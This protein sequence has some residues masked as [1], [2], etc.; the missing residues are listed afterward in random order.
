MKGTKRQFS[1]PGTR[2]QLQFI[3]TTNQTT[4]LI[5]PNKESNLEITTFGTDT[6][7]ENNT[8]Y[9]PSVASNNSP[10]TSVTS[11]IAITF[12]SPNGTSHDDPRTSPPPSPQKNF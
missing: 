3:E 11:S 5:E 4:A 1:S 12:S 6:S 10:L 7:L 2:R 9:S 8:F